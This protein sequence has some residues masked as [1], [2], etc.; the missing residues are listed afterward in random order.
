MRSA[1][2][3]LRVAL[4][5]PYSWS[6]PGGVQAHVAG[7]ARQL[8]ARGLE[9]DI[10]APAD[11]PVDLPG[12]VAVGRSL[13]IPDNRSVQRVALS[14]GAIARCLRIARSSRYDLIH[15]HEPMIPWTCFT[16]LVAARAPLVGTFHMYADSPRWYAVFAP[17]ARRSLARLAA[18]IAVSEAARHHV[19]RVCPG[20]YV[21]IPNGIEAPPALP[22]AP[23]GPRARI[24][25]VGRPERRK[26][27]PVLLEA[28]SRLGGEVELELVGVEPGDVAALPGVRVLGR[29]TEEEKLRRLAAAD[30][31]CAPS[32]GSESFGVVLVEGMAAGLPVVASDIPGYRDLVRPEWGRLVPPGDPQALAAA[33]GELLA[34]EALRARM[35][36]AARQE[37]LRYDWSCVAERILAVY[38]DVLGVG[39]GVEREPGR[40]SSS[41]ARAGL[42]T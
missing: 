26:G 20:R 5:C 21:V 23:K 30:L 39:R 7:L 4:V 17:L 14:P 9:V 3:G 2:A 16:L 40:R 10:V 12:F 34:D 11:G 1:L 35:G 13:P 33:L 27:L 29:A 8:R 22:P 6:Y 15:L 36:E 42:R 32:L 41:G 18:R 25:F 37:A 24:V 28:F 31:L 38:A 19:E